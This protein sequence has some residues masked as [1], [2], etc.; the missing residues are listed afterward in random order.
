MADELMQPAKES[1]EASKMLKDPTG[2]M[3]AHVERAETL[4]RHIEG[5]TR[6]YRFSDI[7]LL[8]EALHAGAAT[9]AYPE[10]NKQLAQ[11]GAKA[12]ELSVCHIGCIRSYSTGMWP[13][14]GLVELSLLLM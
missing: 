7:F 1:T 6:G 2:G 8:S 14:R 3:E 4:R 11:L 12:L 9:K 10:G 5:V 13:L